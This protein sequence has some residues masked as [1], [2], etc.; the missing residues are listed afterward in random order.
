M[1]IID[2]VIVVVFVLG[3]V[4]F[5]ATFYKK[6][7]TSDDFST[8]S[9]KLPAWVLGLSI[10]ATYVSSISYLALPG[11]AFFSN[12]NAFALSIALP[13]GVIIAVKFFVPLYRSIGS[14]SA[15]AYLEER[16]GVWARMYAASCYLLTQIVRTATILYLL[17]LPLYVFLDWDIRLIILLTGISTLI[18]SNLG[19][20]KAV[21]WTDAVQAI[22]MISG[23]LIAL[24]FLVFSLPGGIGQYMDI[25][26]AY[27]KF[28][29]GSFGSSLSE[30]TFWIVF[31]YGL[32][33]SLQNYGIDQNYIQRYIIARNF[34]EAISS[35]LGGGL[36]YIPVSLV[37]FLIGTA[38]FAYFHVYPDM[39]PPVYRESGM[40]DSVFPYFIINILPTGLT[41]LLIAAIISAGMSTIST[42]LNSGS[43]VFL[44]DFYKRI[45]K[46]VNEQESSR[47][48]QI[49]SVLIILLGISI[50]FLFIKVESMFVLYTSLAGI[51]SGGMLG[52][53][54]LG[55]FSKKTGNLPAII[56]VVTGLLLIIWM[57]LSPAVFSGMMESFKSPFHSYLTL[58]FGTMTIFFAGFFIS[59]ALH[60][61]KK[62]S[63]NS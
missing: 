9:G 11:I 17:A 48:L 5:G 14:T 25:G 37:F 29:L 10:L 50:S 28:S 3:I 53:F 55:Y 61:F 35:V 13:F 54:L 12:W 42:S 20:I 51:F 39:L 49:S 47:V 1:N 63:I 23:A 22:I 32:F 2:L 52:L 19:G 26:M 38:L 60:R 40:S 8:G 18:F 43:T 56:G 46:S 34:K 15:Y 33:I 21:V 24:C 57:S 45:K 44:I 41:G 31:V 30:S 7:R 27:H 36:L 4:F 6:N 16:F 62:K 59:W 58:V